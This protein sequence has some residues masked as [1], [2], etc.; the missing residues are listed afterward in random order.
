MRDIVGG[1]D[2]E[3]ARH[4]SDRVQVADPEPGVGVRRADDD[5][6]G[7]V[8]RA[9]VVRVTARSGHETHIFDPADRLTDTEFHEVP[10]FFSAAPD[11]GRS[12][13]MG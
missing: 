5:A 4:A 2:Q 1:E 11:P 3:D 8:G 9:V 7:D 10:R 6:E 12:P 13:L